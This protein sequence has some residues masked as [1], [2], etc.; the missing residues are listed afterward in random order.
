MK[1]SFIRHFRI[2][3]RIWILFQFMCIPLVILFIMFLA[4]MDRLHD[5][6]TR[7]QVE[8]VSSITAAYNVEVSLL[9]LKGLK[10]NYVIYRDPKL[11]RQFDDGVVRFNRWYTES[12]NTAT[13]D[14]ERDV[15]SV[16]AVDFANYLRHHKKIIGL[17]DRGEEKK[18]VVLLAQANVFY[19]SIYNGCQK[20][21]AVN[22]NLIRDSEAQAAKYLKYSRLFGYGTMILFIMLGLMLFFVITRSII[23]P[24][25][26]IEGESGLAGKKIKGQNELERLR[27]HFT[28]IIRALKVSQE[29]LVQSEKRAAIGQVAAGISHELNNPIGVIA[30]FSEMLQKSPSLS[31]KDRDFADEINREARRC[32]TML[33][34]LLE[35]ARTPDPHIRTVRLH[36]IMRRTLQTFAKQEKYRGVAF[37]LAQENR[38]ITGRA[39]PL[40]LQQVIIN[41]VSNACDAMKFK[42]TVSASIAADD[43]SIVMRFA[44]TGPGVKPELREKI[45]RPFFSTKDKGTGLGLALSRDIIER[46]GGS[47]VCMDA[48]AGAVFEITLPRGTH[49]GKRRKNSRS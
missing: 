18:A 11:L 1:L 2:S 12:F 44:D 7:I 42:G 22:E 37:T 49:E 6:Q 38:E 43:A 14:I 24:I 23:D 3:Q 34:N 16:M 26:Q 30:G 13:T 21:I 25:R 32:R 28:T 36:G 33:G 4:A 9:N 41:L 20:L 45:F 31:K 10:A 19:D 8:N 46:H 35:F 17:I 27:E 29:R 47:L 48:D 5:V 39:D 40:Q 15:L